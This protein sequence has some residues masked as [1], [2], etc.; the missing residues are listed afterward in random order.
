MSFC[1][2]FSLKYFLPFSSLHSEC[3]KLMA[4]HYS[5]SSLTSTFC[6]NHLLLILRIE[7]YSQHQLRYSGIPASAQWVLWPS[8]S[9]IDAVWHQVPVKPIICISPFCGAG[10]GTYSLV[11][12]TWGTLNKA[13]LWSTDWPQLTSQMLGLQAAMEPMFPL[14]PFYYFTCSFSC[15][16]FVCLFWCWELRHPLFANMCCC[17][18]IPQFVV[19]IRVHSYAPCYVNHTLCFTYWPIR[20]WY[21]LV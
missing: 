14:P 7:K 2:S 18:A 13:I 16:P 11:H 10:D 20:F 6:I 15:V 19:S 8:G 17:W 4:V 3:I 21:E 1:F 9:P 5:T 12:G